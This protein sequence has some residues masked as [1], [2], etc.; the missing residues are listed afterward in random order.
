MKGDCIKMPLSGSTLRQKNSSLGS[1][2]QQE[3]E[4]VF[5]RQG[6]LDSDCRTESSFSPSPPTDT[7]MTVS[8]LFTNLNAPRSSYIGSA[9]G[10]NGQGLDYFNNS[11]QSPSYSSQTSQ[12]NRFQFTMP[13]QESAF[14]SSF[15]LDSPPAMRNSSFSS[16]GPGTPCTPCT[17]GTPLIGG[18]SDPFSR[19]M[20]QHQVQGRAIR[21]SPPYRMDCGS[22]V[23]DQAPLLSTRSLSPAD[24]DGS[25]SNFDSMSDLMASLNL[26]AGSNNFV[27]PA[28]SNGRNGQS[29]PSGLSEQELTN[30]YA[31]NALYNNNNLMESNRTLQMLLSNLV[32]RN[33]ATNITAAS[34]FGQ[35]PLNSFNFERNAPSN[36]RNH[37]QSPPAHDPGYLSWSG[38]LPQ[39]TREIREYST[40]VFVG[41]IPWEAPE[42]YLISAF[43]QFGRVQVEWPMSDKKGR[44]FCYI[45]FETEKQVK[46]LLEHTHNPKND[47]YFFELPGRRFKSNKPAQIIPWPICDSNYV[48]KRTEK[49]DPH[50]TVF[51]GGLHGVINA[52]CL[53]NIMQDT[54]DGVLYAGIDTDKY[55]Y[56]QGSARIVFEDPISYMRAVSAGFINIEVQISPVDEKVKIT[57]R[58]QLKPYLEDS[59]CSK[60][61]VQR[62][63]YFCKDQ[64]C[65]RYFCHS[66]WQSRHSSSMFAHHTPLSRSS[67]NSRQGGSNSFN[68]NLTLQ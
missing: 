60:C 35:N 31:L 1:W 45:I 51:A 42:Q 24:S 17:P 53:C 3:D 57:Q 36:Y 29:W 54:F 46:A 28:Q 33:L 38:K 15:F 32:Q 49:L 11:I 12:S 59:P 4:V 63:P 67:K 34:L 9:N 58:L 40:K 47:T 26:C 66:C 10:S 8:D 56:P 68:N 62:G 18:Y 20:A 37:P 13:H 21:G 61:H 16:S 64:A 50:K 55:K 41:G 23:I 19:S 5:H 65:F 25:S 30:L 6:S 44:G 39:R 43:Q 22:P 2:F 27:N 52:E 48:R 14:D 7:R